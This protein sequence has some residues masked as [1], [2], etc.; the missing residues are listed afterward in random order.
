MAATLGHP[1]IAFEHLFDALK[2]GRQL[3]SG[4][5]DDRNSGRAF[6]SAI[7]FMITGQALRRDA[8]FV[9]LCHRLGLVDYWRASGKWPDCAT[10]VPYDFKA[11]C[12]KAVRE[13][14]A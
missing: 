4:T 5:A 3:K 8:R 6:E 2:T 9:R 12:E 7:L 11:E 1:D 13:F 10:Q 14:K